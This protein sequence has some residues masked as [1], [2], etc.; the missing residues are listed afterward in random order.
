MNRFKKKNFWGGSLWTFCMLKHNQ[1]KRARPKKHTRAHIHT[2]THTHTHT[3]CIKN[4]KIKKTGYVI[5]TI[6]HTLTDSFFQSLNYVYS[7]THPAAHSLTH[8]L[9]YA[10]LNKPAFGK[11]LRSSFRLS[12]AIRSVATANQ[13]S[14]PMKS[15]QGRFYWSAPLVSRSN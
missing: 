13:R 9:P 3:N 15:F 8:S 7:P 12:R 11:R 14:G 5:P 10:G 2:H 1:T 4:K 6:V